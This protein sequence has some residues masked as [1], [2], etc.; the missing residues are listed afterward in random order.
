[1][2][3]FTSPHPF[4][5]TSTQPAKRSAV[6][7]NVTS[8]A[9]L[10]VWRELHQRDPE[11]VLTQAPEW[12][13]C[14]YAQGGY[15][16]A[17]RL[18]EFENGQQLLMPAVKR[19]GLPRT[20]AVQAALPH[21]WGS[22]GVLARHEP[23]VEE[24]RALFAEL[25]KEPFLSLSISP[26]PRRNS[27]WREAQPAESTRFTAIPRRAHVLDL[28]GGFDTVWKERFLSKTRNKVRKAQKL[29][30]EIECDSSGKLIPIF[31]DLLRRSVDRW[32][33]QQNEP[34]WLS[35]QRTTWRDPL[36]KFEHMARIL[37][38]ACRVRVAWHEGK[39]VAATIVLLGAN[40]ADYTRGA[41][42][43]ELAGPLNAN[44]LL[45]SV[46]I[47]EA[48]EV[49]CRT[50]HLGESAWSQNLSNFKERF[51]A[52]AYEYNEYRLERLPLSKVDQTLRGVVKRA[53]GFEDQSG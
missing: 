31:Y 1:M 27:L 29:G 42:D 10:E 13:A 46:A 36:S 32:A 50:Y 52:E 9:P 23:S 48:C 17:S 33:Q 21:A 6:I 20:L 4:S 51:G 41:M 35:Q 8:P 11:S 47:Q 12:L 22:G 15:T 44:D 30:V 5:P 40:N 26:N 25:A 49:G 2:N 14:L 39:P 37:G 53:I 7:T 19:K 24:L 34:K 43:K 28:T 45:Q 3:S 38:D 16:D 18:Y